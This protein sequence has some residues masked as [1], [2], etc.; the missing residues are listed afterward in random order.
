MT[1][2]PPTGQDPPAQPADPIPVT[3]PDAGGW[4][5]AGVVGVGAASLCSD[6][7]HEMVTSLL[8]AFLTSTLGAGPAALG[9][10]DGFADALTG[11]SKLAGGPL[12]NDPQR[13]GRLAAGG[14]L[15][16]AV[17]TAAIGL[18]VAV[19]QV[20]LLRA[21]AWVSRGL[22][23]PAR[24][25]LLT[26]LAAR[27]AYG[28]AFGVERAGDNAGAI[29]GPLLAAALVAVI[30]IRETMLLSIIPGVLAAV[31]ITIAAR[32]VRRT[33]TPAAGRRTLTLHLGELR[34][35]GL[36]RALTPVAMFELGN[37]ATTLLILRASDLLQAG[38]RDA[39][40][41]TS[42]AI[43]LYAAHNAA[44][45]LAAIG[46]GH[47]ADRFTA[48]H[49]FMAGAAVYIGG[50]LVFAVGPTAW[51]LLVVGFVLC[52]VG[53]GFAETAESTLVAKALPDRLRSNGFGVL[54]LTQAFGDLGATLV[55]G[56]LW[57]L[58]SP[59]IA[60]GYA[61]AWMVGSLLTARM[62]THSESNRMTTG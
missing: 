45:S 18:T 35:A 54:G 14:Y 50:Y 41:A 39:T 44:A 34:R 57:S 5:N 40:A 22:R 38:G 13:R 9:A 37:V 61:A 36:A 31:A 21:I 58:L 17:A 29:L 4:L 16:T 24:D 52:G 32:R 20:A 1:G 3:S 27:D 42:L 23:S 12:A 60:F 25:M 51:P 28:R 26:D 62:A 46:G 8:P 55:A 49:V 43:L 59:S 2:P 48:R 47:L 56:V 30:G 6:A 53:I 19:W 33:L 11:I 7:S 10:I 15:G